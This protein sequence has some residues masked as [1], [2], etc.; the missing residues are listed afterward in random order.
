[1]WG[2]VPMS[3]DIQRGQKRALDSLGLEL[4]VFVGCLTWV[5]GANPGF[6]KTTS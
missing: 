3:S 6:S 1:M 2:F 5:W 4:Q